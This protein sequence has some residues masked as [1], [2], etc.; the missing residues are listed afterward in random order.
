MDT[1]TFDWP[2]SA[3]SLLAQAKQGGDLARLIMAG[4]THIESWLIENRLLP[5][6]HDKKLP[7]LH[8]TITEDDQPARTATLI[9]LPD[10]SAFAC[11]TSGLWSALESHEATHEIQHI[12][13]RF[14]PGD[15]WQ[16][17]FSATCQSGGDE[18]RAVT[19][20]EVA[21]LWEEATGT[22]PQGFAAGRLDQMEAFG[23]GMINLVL[24]NQGRLGL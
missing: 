14:A 23:L 9:P 4:T 16:H 12:G 19:P 13:F 2:Q 7:T 22:R 17:G 8:F 10:G 21:T 24:H 3:L 11:S 1:L 15:H 6:L 20:G 18:A 5:A